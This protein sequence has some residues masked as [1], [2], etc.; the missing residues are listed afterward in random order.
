MKWFCFEMDGMTSEARQALV[1]SAGEGSRLH[2][3]NLAFAQRIR[4]I[5]TGCHV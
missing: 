5:E 2:A 1:L 3:C 4:G